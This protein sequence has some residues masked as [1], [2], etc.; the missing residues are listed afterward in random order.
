MHKNVLK[1]KSNMSKQKVARGRLSA[2]FRIVCLMLTLVMLLGAVPVLAAE[3]AEADEQGE[4]EVPATVT[5]VVAAKDIPQGAYITDDYVKTVEIPNYNVPNNVIADPMEVITKYA[6]EPIYEGEYLHSGLVSARKVNKVNNDLK[7]TDNF[8][9]NEDYLVV[10]DFIMPNTGKDVSALVQELI[11]QNPQRTLYFPDGDY[12]FAS[13]VLTP[14]SAKKSVSI[15]LSDGAVIRASKSWQG[16]NGLNALFCLGARQHENNIVSVGSYYSLMGGTLDGNSKA[17]GI[18][19]DSGRESLIK[20]VCIINA[21]KG[22]VVEDGANSGSSDIDFEDIT[23]IGDYSMGGIGVHVIGYDNT[24]TNMR[25]YNC[26]TGML[27]ESCSLLK[28]IQIKITDPEKV[29]VYAATTGI[30]ETKSHN[31]YSQCIVENYATAYWL[32]WN[33]IFF[34]N[35]AIWN[36]EACASQQVVLRLNSNHVVMGGIS[37]EFYGESD[38]Q[39]FFKTQFNATVGIIEGCSFDTSLEDSDGDYERF[40]ITP[41]IPIS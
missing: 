18:S 15:H 4:A 17:N 11:D 24:F 26:E 41:V 16:A 40:L 33:P 13:P 1:G 36:H 14:A 38:N 27:I 19:I 22:I 23:I 2:F 39:I 7:L 9:C 31:H 3:E 12:V 35:A 21:K 29:K 5:I 32:N 34:D 28:N 30:R 37:A 25:I 6:S 10:T 8:D 20:D